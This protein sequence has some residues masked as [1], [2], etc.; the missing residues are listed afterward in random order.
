MR[1][2]VHK[3]IFNCVNSAQK[4]PSRIDHAWFF[5]GL[6]AHKVELQS[7]GTAERKSRVDNT[8]VG[9]GAVVGGVGRAAVVVVGDDDNEEDEEIREEERKEEE[10]EMEEVEDENADQEGKENDEGDEMDRFEEDEQFFL[11]TILG[12]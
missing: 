6:E 2:N 11:N 3:L 8:R 7:R 12:V 5:E 9:V 4:P 10:E 1:C